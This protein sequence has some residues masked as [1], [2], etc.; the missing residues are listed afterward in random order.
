MTTDIRLPINASNMRPV[1]RR[2]KRKIDWSPTTWVT[3]SFVPVILTG[4]LLLWL[5]IA[6]ATG[7]AVTFLQALFTAVSATCVTGLV[8]GDTGTFWSPF[9]QCIIL[10][11]IQ[12]GGL[13]LITITTFFVIAVHKR[14]RLR[15]RLAF[16]EASGLAQFSNTAALVKQIIATT[17]ICELIGGLLIAWR[18]AGSM[19]W[20]LALRLGLFQG[21]SAFCNSGFDLSG[22]VHGQYSSLVA[23]QEDPVLLG[24]TAFLIIFGGLGFVVWHDLYGLCKGR[25]VTYHTKLVLSMTFI[26]LLFGTCFFALTEWHNQT[27]NG[28]GTMAP[29]H[30]MLNAFFQSVTLRTAGYNSISQGDLTAAG[31][32]LSCLLMF[33]GA[34]PASTAGGIKVTTFAIL[35]GT[36]HSYLNGRRHSLL[37]KHRFATDL[38]NRALAITFIGISTLFAG[39]FLLSVFE[40]SLLSAGKTQVI[41]LLFEV[42][43]AFGTVGVSAVGTPNLSAASQ[44]LLM[45]I[46]FL[47]R[48]G[49]V[50]FA[51]GLT[52]KQSRQQSFIYPDGKT[53]VG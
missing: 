3:L 44:I 10:L 5:P 31:K 47:G 51:I 6:S 8:V 37:C 53:F 7:R 22:L 4:A 17:L 27:A 1:N 14:T 45:F 25:R 40:Q 11:L 36:V 13:G 29:G 16:K 41:D 48:V 35:L 24:L 20:P 30:K 18:Y 12:I 49:P 23:Y 21:V 39:T 32:C 2:R 50:S 28:L 15:A 38:V 42:G 9:G 19:P 34:G 43:S 33:I 46:M 26:L 52:V